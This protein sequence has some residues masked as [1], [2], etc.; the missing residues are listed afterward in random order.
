MITTAM[1][2]RAIPGYIGSYEVSNTGLVRS[3]DRVVTYRNGTPRAYLGV[4]MRQQ[5]SKGGYPHVRLSVNKDSKTWP[6]H[7]LVLL[8]FVG[9]LPVG[10]LTR[11]LNGTPSDNRLENLCY[12]TPLENVRDALRHGTFRTRSDSNM[13]MRGLHAFSEENTGQAVNGRYCKACHR[14]ADAAKKRAQRMRGVPS[15]D[16]RHG[17]ASTYMNFGCRCGPCSDASSSRT[18]ERKANANVYTRKDPT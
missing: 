11:H 7:R 6:V 12:G 8:A 13:C 4:T 16:S 1:R 9:P 5:I 14:V 18:R 10:Q 17:K 3:I 15:G 2:W